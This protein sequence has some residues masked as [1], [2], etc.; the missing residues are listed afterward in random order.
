MLQKLSN[1]YS[2]PTSSAHNE[3]LQRLS[4][5]EKGLSAPTALPLKAP[6]YADQGHLATPQSARYKLVFNS[7]LKEVTVKVIREGKPSQTSKRVVTLINASHSKKT[8][9]LLAS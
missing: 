2:I 5:I 9:K 4:S 7:A 6:S 1:I 8:G 3:T